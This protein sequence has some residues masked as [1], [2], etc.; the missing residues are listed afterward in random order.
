MV[1]DY[2]SIKL[3]PPKSYHFHQPQIVDD[4]FLITSSSQWAKAEKLFTF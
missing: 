3:F 1:C 2:I 4:L